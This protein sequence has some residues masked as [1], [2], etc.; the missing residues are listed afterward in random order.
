MCKHLICANP[1]IS[2]F[3][4]IS[5]DFFLISRSFPADSTDTGS[6]CQ[7]VSS[8]LVHS[9]RGNSQKRKKFAMENAPIQAADQP[10]TAYSGEGAALVLFDLEGKCQVV[11]PAKK[12]QPHLVAG[13]NPQADLPLDDSASSRQHCMLVQRGHSWEVQDM[14]SSNGTYVNGG[15]VQ[16]AVLI[17]G[18]ILQMGHSRFRVEDSLNSPNPVATRNLLLRLF[19]TSQQGLPSSDGAKAA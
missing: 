8:G 15:R 5:V 14:A 17:P 6:F 19:K 12:N 16:S 10:T 1:D 3:L 18:D 7:G 13:R 2:V 4:P 11:L 9:S